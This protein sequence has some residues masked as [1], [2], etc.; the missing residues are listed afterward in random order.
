MSN[1]IVRALE[2]AAQK[3]GTTLAKDASKAVKDFYHSTGHNLRTVASNVRKV[4]EKNAADL[5][6]IMGEGGKHELPRTPGGR[7]RA[8]G[9]HPLGRGGRRG[10]A[11][12][13]NRACST[14]GDPVDVVSGQVITAETDLELAGLLPVVL[15]RSYASSY[16]GGRLFGQGWA[17]TLDERIEI[18]ADGIHYAG[19]DA[20]ILHYPHPAQPGM[21]V[22]PSAGAQWPLTWDRDGDLLRIEDPDRGWTRHFPSTS[23]GAGMRIG[24]IRPLG[25]LADRNGHRITFSRDSAALPTEVSHSCG[26][27]VAVDTVPTA[28]GPRV[29]ELRLLDGSDRGQGLSVVS[30]QYYPDGRLAGVVNSSGLPYIYEY[31]EHG[32]M[33]AWIDRNGHSYEYTYD[34]H[35]RV[36]AGT[37]E[38]GYLAATFHYDTER[39]VTTST[40]SLGHCTEYHYDEQDRVTKTV[41]PLGHTTLTEYDERGRVVARTDEIGR[42][43]RL[44]LDQHGDPIRILEPDGSPITLTYT[45]LR[46]LAT[47]ERGGSVV[48]SF[49]YDAAGNVLT[50]TDAAGAVTVRQYDAQGRLTAATDAMGHTHRIETNP[51]GLITAVTDALG[52]TA[53]V[54]YDAAGRIASFTDPLGATTR[55][56]RRVE[57]DITK[58]IHPDGTS[59]SWAYD[60]EGNCTEQTDQVGAVTRFEIGPFGR[61]ARRILPD[62]EEQH[63]EYDT[64]LQL[65]AV[66]TNGFAWRYRYD[67]AGHLVAESDFNGRT[68]TY[69]LDG[70]D[71]LLEITDS[72]GRSTRFSY[73][74][75]GQLTERRS[76]D[77]AATTLA[78]D[79]RGCLIETSGRGS[80]VRYTYDAA[81]RILTESV[82]GRTTSYTY[83]L[84]GRRT[85]RT[86]PSGIVSTWTYTANSQP[87]ALTG[88]LGSLTFSYDSSGREGTRF[89]GDGAA[90]TQAW[91]AGNRLIAQSIWA[92]NPQ[93]S[94]TSPYTSLQERTY[95]YRSDGMPRTVTDRLRGRRDFDVTPGG[96]ITGVNAHTWNERYVY[97]A[98]GNIIRADDTRHPDGATAGRRAYDGS[99]LRI[100]GRTSYEYDDQGRLVRRL[101]RTLSGQRR[102]WR[103][104]WD[105]EDQLTDVYTPD[106]SRWNYVYDPLGRRTAKRRLELR[107]GRH[108]ALDETVFTWDGTQIAEQYRT[109]PDGRHHSISWDW[110]PG[111]WRPLAQSERT[112]QPGATDVDQQFF[113]IV[114]DL[115][116]A[117]SELV[118]P[119]G[120]IAWRADT[121]LWGRREPGPDGGRPACPLGRPGQYHDEETGL[122]YNLFR[123]YDP[124][125]GRY[126]TSDPLG[127]NA[128]PNPHSYV[129][130]P[131]FWIDPL[132]L[133]AK[134]QPSGWGGWYN[135]LLPANWTDGS[136]NTRYEVNH[137]PAKAT[138]LNLGL[139]RDLKESTGPAIRMEYDDHRDFISTGSGKA[140]EKW[141]AKQQSL[142]KQGK[143]DE[144]MKMD[145]D[146]I[147]RVHG[148]KYDHAIKEMVDSLPQNRQF[149]K[150]LQANGWKIRTCLLQ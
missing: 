34:E 48:A 14:A 77:G 146:E 50:S 147:R 118:T 72:A 25:A 65:L 150:Y 95:T 41:D 98:L 8:P 46:R 138:Y 74:L 123:Y 107:D 43:T 100:A 3:I 120:R 116:D 106:G 52:N 128:G 6:K 7:G 10:Q 4:E 61:L 129:P 93:D 124:A 144:A 75:L 91:D 89:I 97:D 127:L 21:P 51:A 122:D 55:L 78:Y 121:D 114:T 85:S 56:V 126:L 130:N 57:G 96:R 67:A 13:G 62:G 90:L 139:A 24:E 5:K 44:E 81:G 87:A 79:P 101:V 12:N 102:E 49:T 58:R 86:T 60:A 28:G 36:I 115:I 53:H 125:T 1:Q 84:L 92:R 68:L 136:D 19:D 66:A 112:W 22:L 148:T 94:T 117:P 54:T 45:E 16:I 26:Y 20:Q 32:W 104:A 105:G 110:E 39:R 9:E 88:A 135:K 140:S 108:V 132:G 35:G 80:T 82:D 111:T 30:F 70:A 131:L 143:F 11:V 83:D 38:G 119:D 64:E 69:R 99:L 71:Q 17:S 134:K 40:D 63:F 149:Q 15:R 23:V 18:D 59:E 145:I 109:L 42:T 47:I 137:I 2:H 33:T 76:H 113:A 133:M 73:D 141:R 103:Y 37:S 27:R 29:E 142:I 31:D